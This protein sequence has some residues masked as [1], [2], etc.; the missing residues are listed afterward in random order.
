[1][2]IPMVSTGFF[3]VEREGSHLSLLNV[4]SQIH[5]QSHEFLQVKRI[6]GELGVMC[7]HGRVLPLHIHQIMTSSA[8]HAK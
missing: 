3:K 1:M 6:V 7:P 8:P 2:G 4:L 5:H